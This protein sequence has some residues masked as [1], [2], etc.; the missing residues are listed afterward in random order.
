LLPKIAAPTGATLFG[1]F[2]ATLALAL[3]NPADIVVFAALFEGLRVVV[4]TPAE[5]ALFCTAILLGGCAYWVVL[6][7]VL[8]RYRGQMTTGRMVVLNRAASTL[9]VVGAGASLMSIR[10]TG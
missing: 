9:M 6:A 1:G 3:A 2:A 4:Q 7:L 5:V 10:A 8:D